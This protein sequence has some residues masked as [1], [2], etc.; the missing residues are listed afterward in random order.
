MN[1]HAPGPNAKFLGHAAVGIAG[2]QTLHAIVKPKTALDAL[3]TWLI[4]AGL[5]IWAHARFD[6]PIA[7]IIA[8]VAPA[9]G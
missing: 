2:G 7:R 8:T 5:M 9:I 3:V 4:G 1:S 6:L